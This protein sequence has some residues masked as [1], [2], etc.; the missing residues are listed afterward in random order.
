MHAEDYYLTL[1][2]DTYV[3]YS[4]SEGNTKFENTQYKTLGFSGKLY[5]SLHIGLIGSLD[6]DEEETTSSNDESSKREK[7]E[8]LLGI[9]KVRFF[10]KSGSTV[11]TYATE[12]YILDDPLLEL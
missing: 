2:V 3:P 5:D 7:I 10:Y 11:G 6:D 9:G 8:A 12:P 4:G 1:G